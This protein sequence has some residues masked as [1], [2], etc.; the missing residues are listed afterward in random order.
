MLS[1]EDNL[2]VKK[3]KLIVK[4]QYLIFFITSLLLALIV[5]NRGATR[6]TSNYY[7]VFTLID[8][9]DLTDIP[10]FYIISGMEI[11]FGWFAYI[12]SFF[13]D[14]VAVFFTL[15]SFINFYFIYKISQ[16]IKINYSFVFFIYISSS[17]FL[18]QQFMQMRQGMATA[19]QLYA[20][21]IWLID[22]KK[23]S[24]ILLSLIAFSLHQVAL[25]LFLIG[26]FLYLIQKRIEKYSLY[27][28]KQV[29]LILLF[30]FILIAKFLLIPILLNV[31]ARVADYSESGEDGAALSL[32]RLPNI[33]AF[34]TFLLIFM[35][36]NEKLYKNRIFILFFLFFT[37]GLAF[38]IG[39]S[40]FSILSG[41]F[42]IAFSYSEIFILPFVFQRFGKR[43]F[44]MLMILFVII[45]A[46]VTYIFQ[47]PYVFDDYF[48][49]LYIT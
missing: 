2:N 9:F 18:I 46:I 26:G 28:F 7:T 22:K 24:F 25:A 4:K 32:F 15:F 47:A 45:Q 3:M 21:T 12:V 20:F 39:F 36:M 17:Y 37:V 14:S 1:L 31:S 23:L 16:K 41:R 13:T 8:K 5:G 42:A 49:P 11:G 48:K 38:R 40:E 30:I 33:K 35:A 29:V 10:K 43:E 34:L 27:E 44:Y 19:I 6:D